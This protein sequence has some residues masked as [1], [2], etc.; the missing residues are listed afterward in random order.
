MKA[1]GRNFALVVVAEAV[2]AETGEAVRRAAG[3]TA[4]YGGIGQ[5]V[6]ARLEEMTGAETRVAVLGHIQRGGTPIAQD[7][8]IASAF[9]VHA[10][11]VLAEGRHDRLVAWCNRTVVDVPLEDAIR[12]CSA[13]DVDGPLVHTARSLG[14]SFGDGV[15]MT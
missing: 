5:R 1:H 3:E 12:V 8:L 2:R 11:D 14:I 4:S 6:A 10:V 7:R 9:G 15:A 13:V